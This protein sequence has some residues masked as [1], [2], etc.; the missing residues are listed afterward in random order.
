MQTVNPILDV[1]FLLNN[2]GLSFIFYFP[3]HPVMEELQL[4]PFSS[5]DVCSL[6]LLTHL[7]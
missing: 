7:T 4:E 5:A 1:F 3:I 2:A 6:D